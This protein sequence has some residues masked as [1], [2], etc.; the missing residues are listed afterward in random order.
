MSTDNQ[1]I[2][3]NH[4]PDGKPT[5]AIFSKE[6]RPLADLTAEQFLVKNNW[7]SIDPALISRIRPGDNYAAGVE[8]GQVMQAYAI[9][10]VIKSKNKGAKVGELRIGQFNM[11]E[12]SIQEN[13]GETTVINTGLAP[14]RQYLSAVGATG[15]TAYFS[16]MDLSTKKRRKYR[17]IRWRKFGR[18][19]RCPNR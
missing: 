4:L 5:P 14:A 2:I 12:F 19:Y 16:L 18:N 3:L 8:P 11:Q 10:Q 9:G 17:H 13:A 7:I 6:I 1:V 15:L